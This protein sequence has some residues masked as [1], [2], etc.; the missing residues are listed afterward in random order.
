MEC[1]GA[2]CKRHQIFFNKACV[3]TFCWHLT[4]FQLVKLCPFTFKIMSKKLYLVL[5]Q[6]AIPFFLLAQTT[7]SGIVTD[8]DSGES[9][10]GANISVQ[11]T[12]TGTISDV[13]GS[14]QI[15]IQDDATLIISYTGFTTQSISVSNSGG[16]STQNIM[17]SLDALQLQDVIVTANKKAQSSQDVAMSIS[18]LGQ[19]ELTR[20]GANQFQD[21]AVAIPN[22]TFGTQGAGGG[23]YSL[24]RN[25]NQIA[26]RGI[27]GSN[28]TALY[29]DDTPLPENIDPRILD[30]ARVEVLRGPQGTLYGS[31]TLGG[32]MRIISNQPDTEEISGNFSMGV[33]SVTEGDLDYDIKG[34]INL[35]IVKD[36]LALRASGFYAFETGVLDREIIPNVN[37]INSSSSL[38][39]TIA[40]D[41]LSIATDGCVGCGLPAEENIDD[42]KNYG[43][44]ANLGFTPTDDINLSAKIISQST[45]AEGSNMQDISADNFTQLR[46]VGVPE[47]FDEDWTYYSLSGEFKFNK[48]KFVTSTSY[49]DQFYDEQEDEG[50]F[51]STAILGFNGADNNLFWGGTIRAFVDY[52]R[53]THESRYLSQLGNNFDFVAGVFYSKENILHNSASLKP[54]LIS[55]LGA[56]PFL[57]D[58]Q[59]WNSDRT[60]D[61]K[62]LSFFGELYYTVSDKFKIT[63]GLRYFDAEKEAVG[64]QTGGPVDYV[65]TEVGGIFQESGV[66]PKFGIEYKI[67]DQQLLFA[68]ISRGFRLGDVNETV[69]AQFCGDELASLSSPPPTSIESDFLWNYEAGFKGT[70]ANGRVVFNATAFYNNWTNFRQQRFFESCGFGFSANVGNARSI[71]IEA[72]GQAKLNKNLKFGWGL[73]IINAEVTEGG[74]G[75]LAESGDMIT[76]STPV[77]ANLNLEYTKTIN[78][79][80]VFFARYDIQH[81]GE[82]TSVFNPEERP[83][84]VFAPYTLMNLRTGITFENYEIALFARNLG[85][86]SANYG[87][88]LSIAA[89]TPGRPRNVPIM[90]Y[91][92]KIAP[93]IACG[94]S[95]IFKPS[96]STPLTA[97]RLA[98]LSTKISHFPKGLINVITGTGAITGQAIIQHPAVSKITFTGSSN[99]GRI[100]GQNAAKLLKPFTLELGGKN[101]VLVLDDAD[102]SKVP[103]GVCK[104]IFYNQGQ[105]CVSGS[106]LYLPKHKFENTLADIVGIASKMKLGSGF[107]ADTTLGPVVSEDHFKKV[108]H[109]IEEGKT[110][111]IEI[112][113]GGNK[114]RNKGYFIEPT[115]FANTENKKVSVE[116]E[117]IF[118]PVITAMPYDD[119]DDLV[120]KANDTI[121]GLSASIW[122]SNIHKAHT[123]IDKIKAGIIYVNSPVRSDPNLPLGG[124]KQSGIGRELGKSAIDA[125]T[126]IKSVCIN[127]S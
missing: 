101:P 110:D 15:V 62:E 39:Y 30:V 72:E 88:L 81:A 12:S 79:N 103:A 24:G 41:P 63:A 117:E 37:L 99:T 22:L 55:Y 69:P 111:N 44:M 122:T 40:G 52:T 60:G 102:F 10:I 123:L 106:R 104:G 89:E 46:G 83:D 98:E 3:Q 109:Y 21:Y 70:F 11:G 73:G 43:F 120:R 107:E 90:M 20:L 31:N 7:V 113:T 116:S 91:A 105:V 50:S 125:Y 127:Y 8:A 59:W 5:A 36:K 19:R 49:F 29:L 97:L 126:E 85:N 80:S 58:I 14:Y 95:V 57:D 71:G 16:I 82:R 112:V 6:I 1:F 65:D 77:T 93:A 94:C 25:T 115:I 28:T 42:E 61:Q 56:P 48:G 96:E 74:E 54:G 100:I 34:A 26:L 92:W 53:L 114:G 35:P 66:S 75:L 124:F 2:F 32:A 119:I 68:N 67:S 27:S 108:I 23:N 87:D 86:I 64:L 45:R 78:N 76:Y 121:Y 38:N 47:F 13:D 18:V 9:L 118:G 17:L 33:G 4:C 84:R 51:L